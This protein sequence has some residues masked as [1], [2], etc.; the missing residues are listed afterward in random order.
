MTSNMFHTQD[1]QTSAAT[2]QHLVTTVTWCMGFVISCLRNLKCRLYKNQ[3]Q[4]YYC[5]SK[6]KFTLNLNT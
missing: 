6:K 4:N 5:V 2:A 1:P 3:T